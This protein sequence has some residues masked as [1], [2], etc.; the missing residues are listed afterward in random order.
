[1]TP[2]GVAGLSQGQDVATIPWCANGYH[3]NWELFIEILWTC[4]SGKAVDLSSQNDLDIDNNCNSSIE[5]F[6]PQGEL[7]EVQHQGLSAATEHKDGVKVV[8]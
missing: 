3:G 5:H 4:I 7:S 6:R 1:M 2:S 8:R